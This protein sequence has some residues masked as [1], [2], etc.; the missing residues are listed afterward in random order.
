MVPFATLLEW[1][2]YGLVRYIMVWI[3]YIR[4]FKVDRY[5]PIQ[6]WYWCDYWDWL[7]YNAD[8]GHPDEH[9]CVC[10]LKM[11]LAEFERRVV[12]LAKRYTDE[13]KNI[14]LGWIG[15]IHPAFSSL[16]SWVNRLQ[17]QVGFHLPSW[18]ST[19]AR[20]LDWL[21]AKVPYAVR[22]GL[23]TWTELFDSIKE[24]VKEWVRLGYDLAKLYATNA[25]YWVLEAGSS[26]VAWRDRVG[27]WLSYVRGNSYQWIADKLGAGWQWLL[28]FRRNS[29]AWIVSWL[30]EDWQRLIAFKDGPLSFY[31]NLWVAGWQILA[32][33]IADPLAFVLDYLEQA[34]MNRW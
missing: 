14:L 18:V 5:I 25:W 2:F 10:W 1:G 13:A 28:G 22:E 4:P 29:R 16:G 32:S 23:K 6:W 26:L 20:G 31:Y 15:W 21:R 3:P 33:L 9:W 19:V 24:S 11:T 27:G 34:I 30:G 8:N 17:D 7:H 12:D